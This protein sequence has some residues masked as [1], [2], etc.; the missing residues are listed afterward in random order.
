MCVLFLQDSTGGSEHVWCRL[1]ACAVLT[2]VKDPS[3]GSW[4][5]YLSVSAFWE[6]NE[7]FTD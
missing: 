5:H 1:H 4:G 3:R 2:V 7:Q 6:P